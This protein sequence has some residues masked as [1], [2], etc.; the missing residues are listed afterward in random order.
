MFTTTDRT[1]IVLHTWVGYYKHHK[2]IILRVINSR[3]SVVLLQITD[4]Q[5]LD[6]ALLTELQVRPS[7]ENILEILK[8]ISKQLICG[9]YFEDV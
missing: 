1:C 3:Q 2:N 5:N 9:V 6:V 4:S 8:T 7:F